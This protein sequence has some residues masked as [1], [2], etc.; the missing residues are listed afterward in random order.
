LGAVRAAPILHAF[1]DVE[2]ARYSLDEARLAL[3]GFS[4]GTMMALHVGPRRP[5][6]LAGIV[7]YSGMLA[8]EAAMADSTLTRP[9]ILL[10]HGDA[11]PMI[12]VAAFHQAEAALSK[13][14][15]VVEGHV[16]RGLGHSLDLNGLHL[17]EQFLARVLA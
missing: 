14:G 6:A 8:D 1:I 10:I 3:V 9:P 15:F 7:G 12:P 5:R 17:G 13:N 2:L 16:S 11:D 4:Q